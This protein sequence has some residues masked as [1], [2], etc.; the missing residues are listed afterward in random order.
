MHREPDL[1]PIGRSEGHPCHLGQALAPQV[2][3]QLRQERPLRQARPALEEEKVCPPFEPLQALFPRLLAGSVPLDASSAPVARRLRSVPFAAHLPSWAWLRS[4]SAQSTPVAFD[5]AEFG[6]GWHGDRLGRMAPCCSRVLWAPGG[7][8]HG[9][10]CEW[11]L[12][13]DF[14]ALARLETRPGPAPARRSSQGWTRRSWRP[15]PHALCSPSFYAS[16]SRC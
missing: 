13:R 2:G 3:L 9:L 11:T 6:V 15:R 4:G 1:A 10:Q 14:L 12:V 7:R 8:Q 5:S 16:A